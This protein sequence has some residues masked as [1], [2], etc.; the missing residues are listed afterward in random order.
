ML[1]NR[2]FAR[3]LDVIDATLP[4]VHVNLLQRGDLAWGPVLGDAA[5]TMP[6]IV[7]GP[8]AVTVSHAGIVTIPRAELT[9]GWAV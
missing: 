1:R 3:A 4:R 2:G 7:D 8:V 5:I 9:T 6:A